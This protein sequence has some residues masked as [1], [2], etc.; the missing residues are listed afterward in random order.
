MD[1]HKA[2]FKNAIDAKFLHINLKGLKWLTPQYLN[3]PKKEL[4]ILKEAIEIIEQDKL[5]KVII[6]DYQFI[7]VIISS[8]DF[9]P[10]KYWYKHHAYPAINHE[11]FQTY[12]NFF[13]NQLIKN[14]IQIVY[15]IKPLWGDDNVLETIL[16]KNCVKKTSLTDILDSYLLKCKDIPNN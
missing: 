1:L 10:N 15:I 16:N 4:I 5:K 8:Y 7:S 9:S 13:I 3:D 14:K 6:T 12:R 2:N 11:Y